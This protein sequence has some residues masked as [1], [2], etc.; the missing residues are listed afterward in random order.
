MII[1]SSRILEEDDDGSAQN[2]S[3][4]C[5]VKRGDLRNG[6]HRV[7]LDLVSPSSSRKPYRH[8]SSQR[9]S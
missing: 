2:S 9:I 1:Q 4:T 6:R 8:E 5:T 3:E 7:E